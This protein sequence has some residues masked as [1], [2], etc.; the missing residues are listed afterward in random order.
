MEGVLVPREESEN[1]MC[2]SILSRLCFLVSTLYASAGLAAPTISITPS[3]VI[4]YPGEAVQLQADIGGPTE[5]RVK[6]ILQGPLVGGI[7][8]GKL[9][10]DGLYTAPTSMPAGPVRIVVQISTGQWNLPVAAASV[11]VQIIPQG[12]PKPQ[13]GAP[14]PPPPFPF[15]RGDT[16]M[17]EPPAP[18][19]QLR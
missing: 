11:P 12:M 5:Y 8:P 3:P 19:T 2:K 6:W 17:T 15:P 1:T 9:T 10:E 14:P 13:F 4:A 7:D 16:D 18:P